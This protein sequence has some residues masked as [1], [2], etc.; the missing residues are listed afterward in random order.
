MTRMALNDDREELDQ[1][2]SIFSAMWFRAVLVVVVL[3]VIALLAVPHVLDM[4]N[5]PPSRQSASVKLA[6][7][8]SVAPVQPSQPMPAA[9][10]PTPPPIAQPTMPQ[11]AEVAKAEPSAP[12]P[13]KPTEEPAAV[14]PPRAGGGPSDAGGRTGDSQA[15]EKASRGTYW[16]Q[17]GAF[18]DAATAQR[19][20]ERLRADNY[21]V[22]ESVK[23]SGPAP[24]AAA[25]AGEGDRYNV[26]VSGL[27]PTELTAKLGA[28]G[29]NTDV[30]S[31]GVVIKPSLS[32]REAVALSRDLSADGLQVQVR[33]AGRSDGGATASASPAG[34]DASYH[35][36]RVGGFPDKAAAMAVAK[37]LEA[38]GYKPFVA[39]G[40]Q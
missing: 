14:K 12:S 32:L 30:V 37:E 26:F 36:V 19:L 1:P 34:S 11:P 17:V 25:P 2:R 40:A 28:K 5:A 16:V 18:R 6:P 4:V 38:K 33:R 31:G 24:K 35:R 22:A 10:R 21:S 3:G 29:L 27:A 9:E 23:R 15:P 8:P 39:R 20:A 13:P 7:T